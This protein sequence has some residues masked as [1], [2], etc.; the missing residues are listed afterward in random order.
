[1]QLPQGLQACVVV[2]SMI[3]VTA[4]LPLA[5]AMAWLLMQTRTT[6]TKELAAAD[7]N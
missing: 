2:V 3:F 6:G 1:M 4:M 7:L 5:A